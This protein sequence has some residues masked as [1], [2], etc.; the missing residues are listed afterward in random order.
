VTGGS[1]RAAGIESPTIRQLEDRLQLAMAVSNHLTKQ[2]AVSRNDMRVAMESLG[3]ELPADAPLN[4]FTEQPSRT[5][6]A[7]AVKFVQT[8]EQELIS[9]VR[10]AARRE[11]TR[12]LEE[13]AG[14]IHR[15]RVAYEPRHEMLK[16]VAKYLDGFTLSDNYTDEVMQKEMAAVHEVMEE[17]LKRKQLGQ[18]VLGGGKL[19]QQ[20]LDLW[21]PVSQVMHGGKFYVEGYD[22]E[23]AFLKAINLFTAAA[24]QASHIDQE[25]PWTP[26]ELVRHTLSF[27]ESFSGPIAYKLQPAEGVQQLLREVESLEDQRTLDSLRLV[28]EA[29]RDYLA[30][31]WRLEDARISAVDTSISICRVAGHLR[32]MTA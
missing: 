4:S 17:W 30:W 9:K 28:T 27:M 19:Y 21:E 10:L 29:V 8:A 16:I 6:F 13:I 26:E 7:T 31:C 15:P 2:Q 20:A 5:N 23:A 12:T 24:R 1:E 14:L 25:Q 3:I 18:D 32:A 22:D 11:L